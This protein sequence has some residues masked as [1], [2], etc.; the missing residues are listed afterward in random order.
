[1]PYSTDS[2]CW[3]VA[4]INTSTSASAAASLMVAAALTPSPARVAA[5]CGSISKAVTACPALA[6]K[7]AMGVPMAPKP[8]HPT[9]VIS[10]AS[11]SL[12]YGVNGIG[13]QGLSAA[14]EEVDDV[15][16]G[17]VVAY[18]AGEDHIGGAD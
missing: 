2:A 17:V 3:A 11:F 12:W 7:D 18:V 5:F 1:S 16:E 13:A 15:G 9:F 4:T 6:T 14:G 10:V 8:I